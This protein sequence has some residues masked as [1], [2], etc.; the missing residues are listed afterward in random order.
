MFAAEEKVVSGSTKR[1][2]I[3]LAAIGLALVG[4]GGAYVLAPLVRPQPQNLVLLTWPNYVPNELLQ[5]LEQESGIVIEVA[6]YSSSEEMIAILSDP[7][8]SVDLVLTASRDLPDLLDRQL[9]QPLDKARL[10]SFGGISPAHRAPAFDLER[11]YS[12]PYLWGST[13]FTYD[14][15]RTP[16]ALEESWREFFV[17]RSELQGRVAA[18]ADEIEV[19]NAAALYLGIDVCTQRWEDA[20]KI[21]GVLEAQKPHVIYYRSVGSVEAMADGT[22]ILHHQWNGAAHKTREALGT[23]VYVYPE[24]GV[25]YW[26]DNLVIAGATQHVESAH[27]ALEFFLQPQNIA[28]ASNYAGYMNAIE[29]SEAFMDPGLAS[30]PAINP[31]QEIFSRLRAARRCGPEA[32]EVREAVWSR[33]HG[34][35]ES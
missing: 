21:L 33:L 7:A 19:Y 34:G 1:V 25:S 14:S 2:L 20:R 13:G 5:R 3:A 9:L 16:E 11:T 30:D 28:V 18:L 4:V 15:A 10:P 24:E 35:G 12:I 17:P 26:M 31:P 32:I 23:A 8:K 22:V 6:P 29:D 27:Q